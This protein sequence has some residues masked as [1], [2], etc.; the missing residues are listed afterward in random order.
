MA[1]S[2]GN[3][4]NESKNMIFG[5]FDPQ[6]KIELLRSRLTMAT[7]STFSEA[8]AIASI[9][10]K[11]RMLGS[12]LTSALKVGYDLQPKNLVE[13]DA[14]STATTDSTAS[15]DKSVNLSNITQ[16]SDTAS[17]LSNIGSTEEGELAVGVLSLTIDPTHKVSEDSFSSDVASSFDKGATAFLQLVEKTLA[18]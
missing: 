9:K 8:A 2:K 18:D 14:F 5:D 3:T 4:Q 17:T 10:D 11:E 1:R 15:P 7:P 12:A 16:V 6:P 13:N